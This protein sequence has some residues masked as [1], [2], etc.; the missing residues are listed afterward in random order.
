M[1]DE[2][3]NEIKKLQ[4][5][6][7]KYL[8]AVTDKQRMSDLLYEYMTKEYKRM[9]KQKRIEK[10]EEECCKYCRYREYCKFDFPDDIYKPIKNDNA[11]IPGRVTCG[12]FE[13]S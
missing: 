12:N 11:W 8:C 10:Y 1:I 6:K 4:E 9:S 5:Y 7:K 13:W 2:F 3:L